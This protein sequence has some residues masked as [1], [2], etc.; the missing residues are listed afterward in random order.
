MGLLPIGRGR[1]EFHVGMDVV[2]HIVVGNVMTSGC[3]ICIH[4]YLRR[5][6][7]ALWL[8]YVRVRVIMVSIA[9]ICDCWHYHYSMGRV[10][11][12]LVTPRY[13]LE[14]TTSPFLLI[15]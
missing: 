3:F 13:V 10:T 9:I 6:H 7:G 5:R 2:Q 15:E 11:Y 4:M 14:A 12:P 8:P 1:E